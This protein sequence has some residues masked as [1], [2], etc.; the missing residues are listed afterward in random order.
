MTT[1]NRRAFL[2]VT[3]F[4]GGAFSPDGQTLFVKIQTPGVTLAI[5]GPWERGTL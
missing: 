5:W 2:G 1:L 3:P 4:A